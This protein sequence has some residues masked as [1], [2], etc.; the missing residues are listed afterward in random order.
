MASGGIDPR[1][2]QILTIRRIIEGVHVKKNNKQTKK[3]QTTISFV[4]F[5]KAFDFI[6]RGKMEPILL[7]YGIPKETVAA[8]MVLY[9]NRKEK[10]VFQMEIRT[11]STLRQVYCKETHEPY[12]ICLD[13]MLRISIHKM[14]ENGFKL[15]KEKAEGT[16][17]KQL[18]T[19]TT[20][21]I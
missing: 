10:F 15:T 5:T 2:T 6:H 17:H 8:L 7:A 18:P 19:P 4:N 9:R 1:K 21:M 16:L 3:Q 20:P 11:T 14:K 12:I 13:Y